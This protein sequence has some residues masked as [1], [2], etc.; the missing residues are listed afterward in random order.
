M[1]ATSSSR[2]ATDYEKSEAT[3]NVS[4]K[5]RI[6]LDGSSIKFG[7]TLE[8]DNCRRESKVLLC[9][10]RDNYRNAVTGNCSCPL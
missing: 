4:L 1:K 9:Q 3:K 7:G 8:L 2:N 5:T 6:T 10:Y